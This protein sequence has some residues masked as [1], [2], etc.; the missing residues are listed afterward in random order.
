MA[1][2]VKNGRSFHLAEPPD[3]SSSA[4]ARLYLPRQ[5]RSRRI[6]DRG[7]Q[8][9]LLLAARPRLYSPFVFPLYADSTAS[10]PGRS[11]FV[12]RCCRPRRSMLFEISFTSIVLIDLTPLIPAYFTPG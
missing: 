6:P 12:V 7:G 8:C 10:E 9:H 3:A 11:E 2:D 5:K 1:F 4:W